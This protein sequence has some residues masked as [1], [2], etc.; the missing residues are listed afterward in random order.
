MGGC[1]GGAGTPGGAVRLSFSVGAA[2]AGDF[3][4]IC[5]VGGSGRP[6]RG[7]C[8]V[9]GGGAARPGRGGR[10]AGGTGG[11]AAPPARGGGCVGGLGGGPPPGRGGGWV[12]G[13]G[14]G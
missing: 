9:A 6:S 8:R 11:R 12:A 5:S 1:G 14:G 4:L 3:A 7:G 2:S 13:S 10:R